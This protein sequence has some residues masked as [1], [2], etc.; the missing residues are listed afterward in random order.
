MMTH[1]ALTGRRLLLPGVGLAALLALPAL[2][3]AAAAQTT[4]TT[5]DPN[6]LYACYVPNSG[7]VYR[8]RTTDTKQNCASATHV[9]FS[10]N[11]TGP[12]GPKGDKGDPGP[13]GEQG[14]KGD[15]GDPGAQGPAGEG[16]T[17]YFKALTSTATPGAGVLALSLPAGAY[18]LTARVE[19]SRDAFGGSDEG[20]INCS[21]GVPGQ[22]ASTETGQ[23]RI[24]DDEE[25]S[26]VV[27]GAVTAS[28]PFT[29]FLNCAGSEND[30][31]VEPGTSLLAL[32]V[33][34]L[35]VQ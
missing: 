17:A 30:P 35:V 12:Q 20:A 15:P 18:V 23:N 13:Q 2:P 14:D 5:P 22:L 8:I 25:T 9:L 21:I 3:A 24:R 4:T 1:P 7:T 19:V 16:A 34:S 27:T 29:A 10:F 28:S 11:Q 32:K 31:N 6:V 26:L 33:G